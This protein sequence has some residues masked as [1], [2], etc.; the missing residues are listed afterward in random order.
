REFVQAGGLLLADFGTAT[1]N[2]HGRDLGSGQLDEVFG[3]RRAKGAS[4]GKAPAAPGKATL[5]SI[6]DMQFEFAPPVEPSV[7]ATTG[8]AQGG[9]GQVPA[10]I[11]NTL[12]SGRAVFLNLDVGEY[13]VERLN[14]N[15]NSRLPDLVAGLLNFAEIRPL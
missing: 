10:V 4:Q 2:E 9:S 14:P 5:A 11:V 3:I 12:G 8:K 15:S 7:V 13:A 1:M 6:E